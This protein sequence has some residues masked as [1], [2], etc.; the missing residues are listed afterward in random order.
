MSS[1][2]W[3]ERFEREKKTWSKSADE[4]A[5]ELRLLYRR[6]S[7]EIEKE[8]RLWYTRLAEDNGVSMQEAKR[9]L[10]GAQL[11]EFKWNISRWREELGKLNTG[12]PTWER[13]LRN[14]DARQ[15]ITRLTEIQYTLR[16]SVERLYQDRID[17]VEDLMK[18][19]YE[20]GYARSAY[21]TQRATGVGVKMAGVSAEQIDQVVRQKW[22]A[23]GRNFSDRIWADKSALLY[24]LDRVLQ[25]AVTRGER[26]DT[27]IKRFLVGM[28]GKGGDYA[29]ARTLVLSEHARMITLAQL[30][31]YEE[32]GVDEVTVV[33]T[34]DEKLCEI[35][36]PRADDPPFRRTDAVIGSNAPIFHPNCRCV[37]APT[38]EGAIGPE[39]TRAAR[40]AAGKTIFVPASMT[41]AEWAEKYMPR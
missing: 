9:L 38:V 26:P 39:S 37:L 1:A 30:E 20:D 32:L 29:K 17:R 10:D 28:N 2:Y 3:E 12:D 25:D 19:G 6:Q 21:E 16:E 36:G 35:C 5:G 23:D 4:Y 40:D 18:V 31:A 22:G 7:R 34:F 41:Y 8:I 24:N 15:R 27:L 33:V 13:A 14:I 11:E